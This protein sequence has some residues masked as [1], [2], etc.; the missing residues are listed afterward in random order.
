MWKVY[1]MEFLNET[2]V[3]NKKQSVTVYNESWEPRKV[4][5][6]FDNTFYSRQVSTGRDVFYYW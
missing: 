6:S 3:Y 4:F 5:I 1:V 2:F